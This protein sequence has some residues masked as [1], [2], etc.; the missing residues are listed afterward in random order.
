[1][2]K[3]IVVAGYVKNEIMARCSELL[4]V[5]ESD[6]H[7]VGSCWDGGFV[8][9]MVSTEEVTSE[10]AWEYTCTTGWSSIDEEYRDDEGDSIYPEPFS[11]GDDWYCLGSLYGYDEEGEDRYEA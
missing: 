8:F 10:H 4:G 6:L 9:H 1:M 11:L 7:V 5:A 3:C 2:E